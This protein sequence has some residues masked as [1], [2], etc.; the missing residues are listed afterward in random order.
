MY[1]VNWHKD[2]SRTAFLILILLC[3]C[4]FIFYESVLFAQLQAQ[5]CLAQGANYLNKIYTLDKEIIAERLVL[6]K[7]VLR[8]FSKAALLNPEDAKPYF[9]SAE[10]ITRIG[11][12]PKLAAV[13]DIQKLYPASK[14]EKISFDDWAKLNYIEA[15]SREPANA[16][17][18]QRLGSIYEKLSEYNRAEQELKKAVL[19]DPQNASIHLYITQYYLSQDRQSE[20]RY[21]LQKVVELYNLALR[22]G[23]PVA[24]LGDMVQ[25]YLRSI[26]QEHL[27]K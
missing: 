13:F 18:H 12:E 1:L 25:Q 3:V 11:R 4:V 8:L 10:A 23:G 9:A 17:Y 21:H 14:K 24:H 26:N 2:L 27:I 20:F 7:K 16:I 6:Y 19:L 15:V 5:R 22:G